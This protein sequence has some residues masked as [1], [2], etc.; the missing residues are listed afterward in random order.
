MGLVELSPTMRF[1]MESFKQYYQGAD[2]AVPVDFKLR[3]WGAFYFDSHFL[4]RHMAFNDP[5][6]MILFLKARAPIEPSSFVIEPTAG[7][8][9]LRVHKH[10]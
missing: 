9:V 10:P 6:D 2:I 3:E 7:S 1:L 8:P 4:T 5:E